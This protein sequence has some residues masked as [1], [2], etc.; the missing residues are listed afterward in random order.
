MK[1]SHRKIRSRSRSHKKSLSKINNVIILEKSR[2]SG[3][4]F[5]A[6]IGNKTVNFGSEGYSDYRIH[7]DPERM[8]RYENRHRSRENWTKSG[9]KTAGFWAKWILWNKPSLRASIKDTERRFGIK[10]RLQN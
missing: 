2:V 4:K 8:K 5:S 10:I 1:K 6:I 7:K 3:K 9:I